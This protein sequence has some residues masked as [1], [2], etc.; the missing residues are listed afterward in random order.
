MKKLFFTLSVLLCGASA[1]AQ[2][3][4]LERLLIEGNVFK[5]KEIVSANLRKMDKF[6]W[7]YYQCFID[8][9][10]GKNE[11]S[12]LETQMFLKNPKGFNDTAVARMMEMQV[13][14]YANLY[15]YTKA[16]EA[17]DQLLQR[18]AKYLDEDKLKEVTDDNKCFH[19]LQGFAAQS[20]APHGDVTVP[21]LK[22][23]AGLWRIPVATKAGKD[24]FIFD[25]HANFSAVSVTVAK[26]MGIKLKGTS[27][28]VESGATGTKVKCDMGIA[29]SITIGDGVTVRNVVFLVMADSLMRAG[30]YTFNAILGLPVIKALREVQLA[31]NGT[32]TIPAKPTKSGIRNL[33]FS[34][35]KPRVQVVTE[36]KDTLLL[37]LDTGADATSLSS[38]FFSRYKSYVTKNGEKTTENTGGVG[39]VKKMELYKLKSYTF[40][41]GNKKATLSNVT[42]QVKAVGNEDSGALIYGA[43]GEDVMAQFDTTTFNFD[44]MY[45]DFR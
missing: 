41:L 20:V 21:A 4:N 14:N 32:F 12:A 25:T 6:D 29:D 28:E 9:A 44:D 5:L 30:D 33:C 1:I 39:G 11:K 36:D 40:K 43:I 31:K 27:V 16:A 23:K 10:F 15:Q 42:V 24:D 17:G 22:D 37:R 3:D 7:L 45:V 8:N 38:T 2:K 13:Y 26:K 19:A 35:L 34:Q 18:Y